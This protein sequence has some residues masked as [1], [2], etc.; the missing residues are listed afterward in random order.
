MVLSIQNQGNVDVNLIILAY[1]RTN[2]LTFTPGQWP[3]M[4]KLH[5]CNTR[6]FTHSLACWA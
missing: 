1:S 6:S 5:K 3:Q 2:I 4:P